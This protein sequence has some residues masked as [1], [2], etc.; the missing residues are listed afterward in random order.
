[1][2]TYL[3]ESEASFVS[4]TSFLHAQGPLDRPEQLL[5]CRD[6]KTTAKCQLPGG[7]ISSLG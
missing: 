5:S 6:V 1:M 7:F 2:A 4:C 3:G